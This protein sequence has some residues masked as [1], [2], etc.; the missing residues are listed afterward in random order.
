[1]LVVHIVNEASR[2]VIRF[3]EALGDEVVSRNTKV[4]P[5]KRKP[6]FG[7]VTLLRV[8]NLPEMAK[9]KPVVKSQV[10]AAMG[11]SG[12]VGDSGQRQSNQEPDNQEPGRSVRTSPSS[13]R[14]RN[15]QLYLGSVGSRRGS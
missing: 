5:V 8:V 14:G 4:C 15:P 7:L 1:M 10:Y 12:V 3:G 11:L 6:R 13:T 9:P 2:G